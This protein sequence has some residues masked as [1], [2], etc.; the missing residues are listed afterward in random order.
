MTRQDGLDGKKR[1]SRMGTR[2]H[3]QHWIAEMATMANT[4]ETPWGHRGMIT[5]E[6]RD[7]GVGDC[8]AAAVRRT[9]RRGVVRRHRRRRGG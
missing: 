7:D 9:R 3:R 6:R 2:A 4:E 1:A 5:D 8:L